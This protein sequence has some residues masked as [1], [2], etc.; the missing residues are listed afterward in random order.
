MSKELTTSNWYDS[1]YV[2][3]PL[4]IITILIAGI[5]A[6]IVTIASVLMIIVLRLLPMIVALLT[7]YWIWWA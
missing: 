6:L 7:V 2:L 1:D 5:G 4:A 3:L